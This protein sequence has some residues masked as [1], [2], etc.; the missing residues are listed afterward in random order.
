[1][2]S[3]DAASSIS[4]LHQLYKLKYGSPPEFYCV[5]PGRVNLIGEHIDYCGYSVLP[6]AIGLNITIIAG[7]NNEGLVYCLMSKMYDRSKLFVSQN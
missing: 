2:S 5:A 7:V 1:M 4:K 6:M 3:G